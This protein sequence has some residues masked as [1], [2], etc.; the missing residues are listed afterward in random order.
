MPVTEQMSEKIPIRVRK[1]DL[2]TLFPT[3]VWRTRL[4]PETYG[5]I[6]E[7]LGRFLDDLVSGKVVEIGSKFQTE[8]TLHLRP[9]MTE[10][11]ELA[12][13]ALSSVL[14]F[15]KVRHDGFDIT[16]CWANIGAPG[17]PHKMHSHPNNFLSAVYYISAPEGGNSITF[18]DPRP[19][20]A[21]IAPP[22]TEM[23][24]ANAGKADFKVADGDF[25]VFPAW[26]FHSV[27][28]NRSQQ[29]RISIA[30]NF[31]FRDFERTMSPPQWTG[32]LS[33]DE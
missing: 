6:N 21:I 22:H 33:L 23:I 17:S 8:Q 2:V 26:L 14:E 11:V 32:R 1:T 10:L 13:G 30:F 7:R 4:A 19:Q 12:N 9:E 3:F 5:P 27:P 15:L 29:K 24:A 18:H 16:G 25:V 28:V 31:M 20:P